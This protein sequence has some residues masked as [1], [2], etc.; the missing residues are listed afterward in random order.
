MNLCTESYCENPLF[1]GLDDE[2]VQEILQ[3]TR[4]RWYGKDE[5]IFSEGDISR[6]LYLMDEGSVD[7]KKRFDDQEHIIAKLH[8]RTIFGEMALTSEDPR[9]AS[10]I[11]LERVHIRELSASDFNNML[12]NHNVTA[13]KITIN[14]ARILTGRMNKLLQKFNELSNDIKKPGLAKT[15]LNTFKRQ[16]FSDWSF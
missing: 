12:R 14:I 10:V 13:G 8:A 1:A 5:I 11:A 2:E 6:S 7:I 9:S 4:S 3:A 15:D 16:I